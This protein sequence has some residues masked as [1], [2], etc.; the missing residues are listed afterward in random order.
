M[1]SPQSA[2]RKPGL[3]LPRYPLFLNI[4][5]AQQARGPGRVESRI[6]YS[7]VH[8]RHNKQTIQNHP[9]LQIAPKLSNSYHGQECILGFNVAVHEAVSVHCPYCFTNLLN[10]L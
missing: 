9:A 4:R 3:Q 2:T 1:E 7:G 5:Y 8:D 6:A 10:N